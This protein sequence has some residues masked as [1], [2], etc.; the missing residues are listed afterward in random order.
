MVTYSC[1]LDLSYVNMLTFSRWKICYSNIWFLEVTVPQMSGMQNHQ[2]LILNLRLKTVT[3]RF[4]ANI[5]IS[6]FE[7]SLTLLMVARPAICRLTSGFWKHNAFN[8]SFPVTHFEI[9]QSSGIFKMKW[10]FFKE[11]I[12][13]FASNCQEGLLYLI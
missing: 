5:F 9:K 8:V 10:Y 13:L 4:L 3:C 7:W 6:K 12:Y 11:V 2:G 1:S